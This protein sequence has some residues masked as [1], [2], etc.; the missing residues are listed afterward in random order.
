M[1]KLIEMVA[2]EE[3]IRKINKKNYEIES[4]KELAFKTLEEIDLTYLELYKELDA[5]QKKYAKKRKVVFKKIEKIEKKIEE[6]DSLVEL[7]SKHIAETEA[8][9]IELKRLKK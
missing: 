8:L 3:K 1:K 9:S 6:V 5:L 2:I 7:A 4:V